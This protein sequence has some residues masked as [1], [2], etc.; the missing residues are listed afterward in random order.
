MMALKTIKEL[1]NGCGRY[2]TTNDQKIKYYCGSSRVN[3]VYCTTCKSLIRA[4]KD[5]VKVIEDWGENNYGDEIKTKQI[6]ELIKRIE[7]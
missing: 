1:E 2:Y 3:K 4:L 5:V 7:G 6:R